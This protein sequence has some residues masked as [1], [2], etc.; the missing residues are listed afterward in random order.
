MTGNEVL[1]QNQTNRAVSREK[2]VR[3]SPADPKKS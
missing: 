3:K 1:A 2:A